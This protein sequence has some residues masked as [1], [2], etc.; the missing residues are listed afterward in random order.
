[1]GSFANFIV[2]AF[3]EHISSLSTEFRQLDTDMDRTLTLNVAEIKKRCID[4]DAF[5]DRNE[6]LKE[7]KLSLS[8]HQVY[9]H[10]SQADQGKYLQIL[11][12][13]RILLL[14]LI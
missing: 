6:S 9:L 7:N 5:F 1:M 8:V 3:G 14:G 11:S 2:L 13:G 10:L 12:E 4:S